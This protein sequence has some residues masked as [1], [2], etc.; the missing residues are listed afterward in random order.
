[1]PGRLI[2]QYREAKG[3]SQEDMMELLHMSQSNYSKI[4][5]NKVELTARTARK[6]TKVLGCTLED[7]I[8]D[9]TIIESAKL[10]KLNSNKSGNLSIEEIESLFNQKFNELKIW[11]NEK[12][13]Q[14]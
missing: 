4:E 6:I 1:M 8:P 12:I 11:L 5:N 7:I 2:K 9:D 14:H 13:N 10:S 3:L